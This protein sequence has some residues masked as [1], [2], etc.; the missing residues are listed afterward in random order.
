MRW[1]RD[2]Q[3]DMTWYSLAYRDDIAMWSNT[4]VTSC[5][6]GFFPLFK[7]I[8]MTLISRKKRI[9]VM[10]DYCNT[11]SFFFLYIYQY[12]KILNSLLNCTLY[13]SLMYT[14]YI[15]VSNNTP[16][17]THVSL[18]IVWRVHPR[19]RMLEKSTLH[20]NTK[21]CARMSMKLKPLYV[22]F[23]EK[24]KGIHTK[25]LLEN[26]FTYLYQGI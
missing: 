14:M 6:C 24:N 20:W 18:Y 1:T 11:S 12:F 15:T 26:S 17:Y 25:G 7:Y 8:K 22:G 9:E 3:I 16:S 2:V 13:L 10:W 23:L 21:W 4:L 19:A 5:W